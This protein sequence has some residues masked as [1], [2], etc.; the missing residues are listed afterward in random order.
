MKHYLLATVLAALSGF[1]TAR[2]GPCSYTFSP[3]SLSAAAAGATGSANLT[4]GS[5]CAWT[6]ASTNSWIH[7]GG[8]GPGNGTVTYTVD[9]NLLTSPRTGAITA[10]TQTLVVNQAAA[11]VPLGQVLN[12]TNLTWTTSSPYPWISTNPPAPTFDGVNSAVSG[13]R[14]VQNSVSW[15]QTTVVGPGTLTFWWKVDSDVTP[16][17]PDPPVSYDSLEFLIDGSSQSQI[18]GQIDWNY[19]TFDIP[20][21]SHVLQWQYTKDAQYN[22]GYDQAWLDQVIYTTNSPIPLQSSLNTCGVNWTSGGNTNETL[23]AG[24]AAVSHDGQTAAQSGSVFVNQESWMQ[25]VVSGV[26][27][28][29][30]GGRFRRR[31]IMIF[32]SF[33]PIM[34]WPGGSP[35]RLHGNPTFSGS[36]PTRPT[37]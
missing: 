31:P 13:N 12:S 10:G 4:A 20:A 7:P 34:F 29:S 37:R 1:S 3:G 9:P 36:T 17:L 8:N 26:T 18:M 16:P 2:G 27:N 14:G 5:S 30:F 19:R 22:S 35:V 32:L 6:A 28:L 33:I 24:Q 21:G 23:W 15:L 11:P 25:A